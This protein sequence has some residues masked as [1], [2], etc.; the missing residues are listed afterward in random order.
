[1]A[2]ENRARGGAFT[3][4]EVLVVISIIG[5]LASLV[6][7]LASGA[8]LKSKISRCKVERDRIIV[9]MESYK[10]DFGSYPPDNYNAEKRVVNPAMN[11]LFYELT[12]TV[13]MP[14][15]DEFR[16]VLGNQS[17]S[18]GVIKMAFNTDGFANSSVN[19]NDVKRY[20]TVTPAQVGDVSVTGEAY[21]KVLKSPLDWLPNRSDAPLANSVVNPWRYV[22]TG[23]TNN[24]TSFDLWTEFLVGGK[25]RTVGN[26]RE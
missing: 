13:F 11:S 3:L 22:R 7:S 4:I 25:L 15:R 26:W 9:A 19:T 24:P 21:V 6:V 5:V 16:P 18:S 23:A 2:C 12:G 1:M 14:L 17:V 8:T 10:S 20:L